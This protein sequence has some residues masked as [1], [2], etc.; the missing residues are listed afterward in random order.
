MQNFQT[1]FVINAGPACAWKTVY[2]LPVE[3]PHTPWFHASEMAGSVFYTFSLGVLGRK[4]IFLKALGCLNLLE[5][6]VHDLSIPHIAVI[7]TASLHVIHH[8]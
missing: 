2:D 6:I 7:V 5:N 8:F 3:S 4:N 1:V